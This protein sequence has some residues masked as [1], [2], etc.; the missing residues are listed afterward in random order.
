MAIDQFLAAIEES[1]LL[2]AGLVAVLFLFSGAALALIWRRR[3]LR[4]Y[5]ELTRATEALVASAARYRAVT[6]TAADAIVTADRSGTI[7]GW[8]AS[9]ERIFGYAET[10]AVG[11]PLTLLIPERS[12]DR[13]LDGMKRVQ[14]GGERRII[15]K[16]VELAGRRKDASEFP[17]DLTLAEWAVGDGQFFTANIR[18]ITERKQIQDTVLQEKN[19]VNAALDSLPGMFYVISDQGRFLR[20]N[21]NFEM[22]SGYSSE[23]VSRLSPT[24]LFAGPD[25][26]L[27]ADRIRQVFMTGESTVEAD[28]VAKDGTATSYFFT[29]AL[30]QIDQNPCLIGMGIDISERKKAEDARAHREAELEESQRIARIGSWEWT[31]ATGAFAWS[32]GLNHVLGR[33]H[34]SP[35]PSFETLSQFYTAESWQRLDA[36]IATTVETGAPYEIDV[37]MIRPDGATCWTTTR[38]EAIRGADGSVVK[39]RGTVH[40]ITTRREADARIAYL[41]RVYAMLSGIDALIVRVHERDE[42]FS[43]TCR[44]AAEAGG[45]RMALIGMVDQNTTKIVPVALAGKDEELLAAI[46][47]HFSSS[48]SVPF[49]SPPAGA[50][51]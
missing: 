38:G 11:Q 31:I 41:N 29:G 15:G 36:V 12:Q 32:D 22:L 13:H 14:S 24:D 9:A 40:D 10:E 3:R 27:V 49:G 39:L 17:L 28:L 25:K 43:H 1:S 37:Q 33:D 23:D 16:T 34:G 6:E 45:F 48:E 46:K 8:N 44:I 21:R 20:W 4:H 50:G 51:D 19:F 18:D 35:A 2:T 47:D 7:V 5:S 30:V 26:A 42:L